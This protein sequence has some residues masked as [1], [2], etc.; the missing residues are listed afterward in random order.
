M[1]ICHINIESTTPA[2]IFLWKIEESNEELA[3]LF[4]GGDIMLADAVKHFKSVKRQQEWLATRA[5]LMHTPY[6]ELQILYHSNGKPYLSDKRKQISISHTHGYVAIAISEEP[7][8]VDIETM[9]RNALHAATAY[10]QPQEI[11]SLNTK[12]EPQK[13][14]LRL[15]TVKEAAFKLNSACAT[16]IKDIAAERIA[17]NSSASVY[18][19]TYKDGTTAQCHTSE[20][21]CFILSICTFTKNRPCL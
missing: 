9:S 12:E 17:G 20:H 1:P 3:G 11:E 16:V 13:E 10:L 8:G 15:W 21:R 14:A 18:R 6:K 7:I 19:I 5:L 2:E 4:D